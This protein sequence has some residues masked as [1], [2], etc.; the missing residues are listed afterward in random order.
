MYTKRGHQLKTDDLV[1]YY[2][3]LIRK[4]FFNIYYR[5]KLFVN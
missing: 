2:E 3:L 4:G 1:F 5:I